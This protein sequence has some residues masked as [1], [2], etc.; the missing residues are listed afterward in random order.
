M[1]PKPIDRNADEYCR[2]R[3]VDI[4]SK[5]SRKH[6]CYETYNANEVCHAGAKGNQKWPS[7]ILEPKHTSVEGEHR[8]FRKSDC[9]AIG[10]L[11]DIRGDEELA[12]LVRSG[13]LNVPTEMIVK[14]AFNIDSTIDQRER[15]QTSA[16]PWN[17]VPRNLLE[18]LE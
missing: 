12:D 11:E 5:A 14:V 1:I 15:L 6:D 9:K 16:G 18:P 2:K 8:K 4:I 17:C 10:K 7:E 13:S 3:L